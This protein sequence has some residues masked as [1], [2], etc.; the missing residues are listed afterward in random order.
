[1]GRLRTL[2]GPSSKEDPTIVYP[3]GVQYRPQRVMAWYKPR[4]MRSGS[5]KMREAALK[6]GAPLGHVGQLDVDTTGL[7]L[8]TDD[9]D[10]NN[11]LRVR[12]RVPKTYRVTLRAHCNWSLSSEQ[13]EALLTG[14]ESVTLVGQ[15]S[16]EEPLLPPG[17]VPKA[18]FLFDVVIR[19]GQYHIVKRLFFHRVGMAVHSLKRTAIGPLTLDRLSLR[20][21]GD[22][23][24]LSSK[25]VAD[26]WRSAG[27]IE[28]LWDDKVCALRDRAA[29][30]P[31]DHRLIAFLTGL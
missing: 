24:T 9:G 16:L 17:C 13:K 2:P 7:W 31:D 21:P 19:S 23:A 20:E 15:E 18:D 11:Q 14:F 12:G 22:W 30:H 3:S 6:V 29:R 10:L 25:D 4:R 26:L 28:Q 27:G 1:M 5:A 8:F